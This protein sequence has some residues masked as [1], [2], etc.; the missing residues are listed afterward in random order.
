MRYGFHMM[1]RGITAEPDGVLAIAQACERHGFDYF[2]VSDHV[3]VCATI[4]SAYPYSPDGSWAG[5][6]DPNC[7]ETLTTLGFIAAGTSRIRLLPSVLVLP[8][9][10]PILAAKTLATVDVLSKGR[11]TL[12]I[13]VGWMR[14]EMSALGSPP[15]ERRGR[16]SDEYVEV[17]R[18]LW[19]ERVARF[20]GEFVSFEGVMAEPKPV[21]KLGPP[22]W[23]GG[24]GPV[25][26]RR[27]ARLGDGWYPV[28]RNPHLRCSV[29]P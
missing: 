19:R 25:A 15:Y 21:Q 1:T 11:L 29:V 16:A 5:A 28:G 22:I 17:F 7:L 9:R 13:G 18:T 20:E 10:P 14:E 6:S 2:G 4:D 24:E 3:I 12:G 23:V 27:V 8:H 26:R